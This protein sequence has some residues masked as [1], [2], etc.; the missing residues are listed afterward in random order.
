[1]RRGSEYEP[2]HAQGSKLLGRLPVD[3]SPWRDA[4][5]QLSQFG[6]TPV[7]LCRLAQTLQ[8]TSSPFQIQGKTI[9]A[10]SI[11]NGPTI[12]RRGTPTHHD[13]DIALGVC[14]H[15]GKGD[16][17]AV[18]GWFWLTPDGTHR[19][20]VRL[21]A[22]SPIG[23]GNAKCTK[24]WFQVAHPEA[25]EEPS[26]GEFVETDQFLGQDKGIALW[27]DDDACAKQHPFGLCGQKG[28]RDDGVQDAL[29]GCQW[30]GRHPGIGQHIVFSGAQ[31]V[32]DGRFGCL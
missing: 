31:R 8:G 2:M 20:Q 29:F 18:I 4:D 27:Q 30:S 16:K 22:G 6:W 12:C 11:L 14:L 21:T 7:A 19:W 24:L 5:L 25:K 3:W 26:F 28:E 9:P 23:K 15:V 13:A 17:L 1:M 10:D 32:K